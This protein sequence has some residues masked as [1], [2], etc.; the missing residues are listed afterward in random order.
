MGGVTRPLSQW[1]KNVIVVAPYNAQ[2]NTLRRV[3]D[4]AGFAGVPVG[5]V[6]KFQGQE[7]PIAILSMAAS[8]A[9]EVP[10]G[11]EFLLMRNRLNVALSRAQWAAYV[12]YSPELTDFMPTTPKNLGLLSGFLT[13]VEPDSL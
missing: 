10:R 4:D 12:V 13:L 1:D 6:D 3:L 5:T 2:V 9:T 11:V 8:S 7:A